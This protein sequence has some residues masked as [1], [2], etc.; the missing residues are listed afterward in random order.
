[1]RF[2]TLQICPIDGHIVCQAVIKIGALQLNETHSKPDV[3]I[4]SCIFTW[5]IAT[6][7]FELI[8]PPDKH[9]LQPL[10]NTTQMLQIYIPPN[11]NK[12]VLVLDFD[13]RHSSKQTLRDYHDNFEVT[14]ESKVCKYTISGL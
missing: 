5:N 13:C 2:L 14:L 12:K 7:A 1:M 9:K 8:E 6:D 10:T 11:N 3:Y 4:A